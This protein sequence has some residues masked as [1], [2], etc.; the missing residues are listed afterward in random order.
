MRPSPLNS[1]K[2]KVINLYVN[3]KLS[4]ATTGKILG[5]SRCGIRLALKRWGIPIRPKDTK[6]PLLT[7]DFLKG[8]YLTDK[9]STKEI[10]KEVGVSNTT[11]IKWLKVYKVRIRGSRLYKKPNLAKLQRCNTEDVA[12]FLG[13]FA[14]D[15]NLS[16]DSGSERITFNLNIQDLSILRKFKKTL[17]VNN[18]ITFIEPKKTKYKGKIISSGKQCVLRVNCV[19]LKRCLDRFQLGHI[20]KKNRKIIISSNIP[21]RLVR[22]FIR[23]YFDGDGCI[24]IN[25]RKRKP[26][27]VIASSSERILLQI[28]GFLNREGFTTKLKRRGDSSSCYYLQI[29]INLLNIKKMY[30]YLYKDS[31]IFLPRKRKK[32]QSVLNSGA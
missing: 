4:L 29:N 23:G 13:F 18:K 24:T 5:V 26:G 3:K 32:F 2:K 30:N 17:E 20:H 21:N 27:M 31:T 22:H 19:G 12:Y 8:S 16:T 7:K 28:E 10:G 6:N 9:K 14:A 1:K 15:G 25:D 11:V